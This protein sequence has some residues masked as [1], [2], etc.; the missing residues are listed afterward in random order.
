MYEI[1][2]SPNEL[3]KM[4]KSSNYYWIDWRELWCS[5]EYQKNLLAWF[6][7][8]YLTSISWVF[9][10]DVFFKSLANCLIIKSWLDQWY[11]H[12][13][14]KGPK[15]SLKWFRPPCCLYNLYLSKV[16]YYC[17]PSPP[18]KILLC[19]T[20]LNNTLMVSICFNKIKI[21]V[22]FYYNYLKIKHSCPYP[23]VK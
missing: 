22:T 19:A 6:L 8:P 15:P 4:T 5:L 21:K 14:V 13:K 9:T 18:K 2:I 10:P 12:K 20:G 23:F 17:N 11:T 7:T 1:I 3:S 16:N